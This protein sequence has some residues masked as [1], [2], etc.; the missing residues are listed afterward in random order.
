MHQLFEFIELFKV[1]INEEMQNNSDKIDLPL[2]PTHGKSLM[3]LAV[4]HNAYLILAYMLIDL[5]LNP[6]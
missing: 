1:Y 2:I 3:H 4:E 5:K 6:N